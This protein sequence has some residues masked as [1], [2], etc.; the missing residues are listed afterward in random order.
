MKN[1]IC[2]LLLTIGLTGCG[3]K[4]EI[5]ED[6]VIL[7]MTS[8]QWKMS[9]FVEGGTDRTTEFTAYRFKYYSNNTVDAIKNGVVEK[10][11]SWTGSASTIGW[12]TTQFLPA[13]N[14]HKS[15]SGTKNQ[16]LSLGATGG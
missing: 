5:Q 11:G 16:Y 15:L 6:L 9:S 1:F 7:A 12:V 8:G 3:K 4:T 10:S 13:I 2:C 14:Y